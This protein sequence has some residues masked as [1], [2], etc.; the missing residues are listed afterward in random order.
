MAGLG[1]AF[2]L[3]PGASKDERKHALMQTIQHE[4]N[5]EN[6]RMLIEKINE[7]CFEKCI[8]KPGSSLSSGESL[9]LTN[10]MQKY[11]AAWNAV[12]AAYITRIKSDPAL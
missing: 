3:G 6:A 1:G 11:M 7:K 5:V 2:G 12:S 9:C 8:P 4:T 10:C